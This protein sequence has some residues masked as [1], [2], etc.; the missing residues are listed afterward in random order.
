MSLLTERAASAIEDSV[1]RAVEGKDIAV[2]FSGGLDSG[3]VGAL[4]MKYASSVRMYVAGIPGSHDVEAATSAAEMLG[5]DLEVI[6]VMPDDAMVLIKSQMSDT[7][8]TNPLV[9]AF[10]SP[11]Y[12]VLKHCK[13]SIVAAGQGADEVFGGYNK[14]VSV[15]DEGLKDAMKA[16]ADRF[17]AQTYPHE[18]KIA[19]LFGKTVFRP[20]FDDTVTSLMA[21]ASPSEI[22]PS[23][24]DRKKVL[25]DAATYLGYGFL[26]SRPKKAAQYGSG[27]LDAVKEQCRKEGMQYNEFVSRTAQEL[28]L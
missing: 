14:Y 1:R 23:P 22:R 18:K 21:A 8:M 27:I 9:L 5:A 20:Y 24:E 28:G 17:W 2:A 3:L 19:D 10:T 7:G 15:P 6:E 25:C 4:S 16:D 12:C 13:D 11:I 26:A